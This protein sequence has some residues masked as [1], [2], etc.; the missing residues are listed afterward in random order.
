MSIVMFLRF[1]ALTAITA[2]AGCACPSGGCSVPRTPCAPCVDQL[3]VPEET[4]PT[5]A[6]L[7]SADLLVPLP[8][9]TETYQSLDA[10]TCQ[11]RA[12]TNTTRANLVELERHW[13]KVVLECDT[14]NVR[15]NLCLDRDLLALRATGLRNEAAGS[16][17]RSFYRLAGLEVQKNY[18]QQGIEESRLTL[19]RIDKLRAKGIELPS[20]I[21]R[22]T[23][24]G[25]LAE[26]EDQKLQL[27]FPAYPTQRPAPKNDGLLARRIYILLA[28]SRLAARH[29][30]G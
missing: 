20:E 11:C 3:T 1:L 10:A 25:Q 22:S 28:P 5:F 12:A 16:A 19:S 4:Q 21:D 18:L 27:D 29:G 14:K 13:A 6:T 9:P 2:L 15:K 30:T 24:V 23:I 8:A 7:A 17:L 26:L